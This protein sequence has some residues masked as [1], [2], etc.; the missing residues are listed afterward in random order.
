MRF[1]R[2]FVAACLVVLAIAPAAVFA[3]GS[4]R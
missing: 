2:A 4:S 3:Q 1:V